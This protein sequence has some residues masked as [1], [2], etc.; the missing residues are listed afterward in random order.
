MGE[1]FNWHDCGAIYSVGKSGIAGLG[2]IDSE[3]TFGLVEFE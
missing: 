2:W 3:C 1:N